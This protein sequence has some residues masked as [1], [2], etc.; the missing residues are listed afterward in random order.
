MLAA[1][2]AGGTTVT[3]LTSSILVH[4]VVYDVGCLVNLKDEHQRTG[5]QAARLRQQAK[6]GSQGGI[7]GGPY[8]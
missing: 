1:N 8:A 4:Q 5:V 3:L 6:Q 2:A 7:A